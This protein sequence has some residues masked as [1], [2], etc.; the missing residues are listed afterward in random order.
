MPLLCLE[1]PSAVG[2]TTTSKALAEQ[3]A[4]YIVPE[5]NQL[6]E[7]PNPEPTYWYFE[8]QVERWTIAQTQ[9]KTHELVIFD[10]DPFQPLWYNWSFNFLDWQPLSVLR[11]FYRQQIVDQRLGFPDGYIVLT[12]NE[13][14]LRQR[15]ENDITRKRRGFD[16][17]LQIIEP[18][19]RYF[20][21]MNHFVP[22]FVN[23]IEAMSIEQNLEHI[24]NILP[25]FSKLPEHPYSLRLFD[26]LIEWLHGNQP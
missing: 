16:R 15:K 25:S 1:G 18:Q 7:R 4:A 3:Y 11:D 12:I 6:F 10:G 13:N 2:K 14:E 17:H 21:A 9:L 24:I 8:R 23:L 5:V 26:F 20:Q 22:G 19:K